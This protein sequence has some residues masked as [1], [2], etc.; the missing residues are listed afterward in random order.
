M[1]TTPEDHAAN[2]PETWQVVK[3][4]PGAWLLTTKDDDVITSGSTKKGMEAERDGGTYRRMYDEEGRWY[5]GETRHGRRSWAD[6]KAERDAQAAADALADQPH[7]IVW[8]ST[9][10]A[11]TD[12]QQNW[13]TT[14][15]MVERAHRFP[16]RA[17]ARARLG[18]IGDRRNLRTMAEAAWLEQHGARAELV[19]A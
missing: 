19:T 5:A 7:V 2:P 13:Q 16:T 18:Q 1:F 17:A 6:V 9:G 3:A 11:F 4:G 8:R 15:D 14:A 10:N 12:G